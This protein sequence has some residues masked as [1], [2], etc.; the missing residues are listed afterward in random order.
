MNP[1]S[2]EPQAG[3]NRTPIGRGHGHLMLSSSTL[4]GEE[5][6]NRSGDKLGHIKDLVIDTQSGQVQYAV[7]STGGFLGLG[8]RLFALPWKALDL[9]TEHHNFIL[10]VGVERLKKAPGFDKDHW[11][12]MG[13]QLWAKE[14]SSYYERR[15]DSAPPRA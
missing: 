9:D 11:P 7:M 8:D 2:G 4:T 14:V 5:V 12:D 6:T 3:R 1:S 10:D 13:D 15:S